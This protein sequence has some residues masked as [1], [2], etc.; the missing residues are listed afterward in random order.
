MSWNLPIQINKLASITRISGATIQVYNS[1]GTLLAT[2]A[3]TGLTITGSN[4]NV[5][6]LTVGRG[7]NTAVSTNTALGVNALFSAGSFSD[8]LT[9]IGSGALQLADATINTPAVGSGS[10]PSL[11]VGGNHIAIGYNSGRVLTGGQNDIYIGDT[12][13]SAVNVSREIVISTDGAVGGNIGK[14]T[15]TTLI[16]GTTGYLPATIIQNTGAII[17]LGDA[18]TT[19]GV[20][21]PTG[22][23][24]VSAGNV[25]AL[26]LNG[27]LNVVGQTT[28]TAGNI[29]YTANT[30]NTTGNYD[31]LTDSAQHFTFLGGSGVGSNTMSIGGA[32]YGGL[33]IPS[34]S[35]EITVNK[36]SSNA[37]TALT[38]NSTSGNLAFQTVGVQRATIEATGLVIPNNLGVYI[39]AVGST[40][41]FFEL[42]SNKAQPMRFFNSTGPYI[43]D[44]GHD[45]TGGTF[46]IGV[47]A[48]NGVLLTYLNNVW[49]AYSDSRL[50][51][52]I[53]PLTGL[54]KILKLKPVSYSMITNPKRTNFGFLAQD[55]LPII[56]EIVEEVEYGENEKRYVMTPTEILPF[57]VK[58]IQE[59]QEQ[60]TNLQADLAS[61]KAVVDA[62]VAHKDLLVV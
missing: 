8:S 51:E 54:A 27:K 12:A 15:N 62:L 35:G 7:N 4:I 60:I 2:Y 33:T 36:V 38:L 10:F 5:N 6:G 32:T 22:N 42:N 34:T 19:S 55:V 18:T 3:T 57:A 16:S 59:Q 44:M 56:P 25:T 43:M 58:A 28:S 24:A 40:T 26:N 46:R 61:L 47:P 20:T 29:L 39:G 48:S 30:T 37:S 14:G 11:S 52:N 45:A 1:T 17:T 31:L 41:S 50:K 13:A 49:G 9:A 23:L 53:V 21:I